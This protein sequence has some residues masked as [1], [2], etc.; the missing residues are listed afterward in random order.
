M[1]LKA[2]HSSKTALRHASRTVR[3]SIPAARRARFSEQICFHL[4]ESK[5]FRDARSFHAFWPMTDQAEVDIRPLIRTAYSRGADVWLPVVC[6]QDLRHALFS[7]EHN[8]EQASFGQMEPVDQNVQDRIEPDLV[9]VPGLAVDNSGN[10]LGY[11]GGYYDRF[12][13]ELLKAP[14]RGPFIMVLF[15]EQRVEAVPHV[16]HDVPLDAFVTE[17]GMTWCNPQRQSV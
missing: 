3:N 13:S 16:E 2:E 8:L 14:N 4:S 15:E 12:L 11:G 9:V 1:V 10:R 7:G 5:V 17:A 6:G